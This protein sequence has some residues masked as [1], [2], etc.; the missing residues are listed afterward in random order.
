MKTWFT[1]IAAAQI[2]FL[3][4]QAAYYEHWKATGQTI[5]IR[6][7]PTD[8]RSLF[9]GNYLFLSY[10]ISRPPRQGLPP[11][12]VRF[13]RLADGTRIF[14]ELEPRKGGAI[15]TGLYTRRP[16]PPAKGRV[17][18]QGRKV[19]DRINYGLERYYIPEARSEAASKLQA[20]L[21]QTKQA[22]VITVEVAV[23]RSGQGMI[24]RVL[25]DGKPLDF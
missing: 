18:L 7:A 24:R 12:S 17:Y 21:A 25:V 14:V 5:E 1:V 6:V 13:D 8:P 15:I 20:A 10:D 22:P 4:A 23:S 9:L 3:G 11:G 16:N 2:L 19:L